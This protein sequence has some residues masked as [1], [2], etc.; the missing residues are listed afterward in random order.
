MGRPAERARR[1]IRRRIFTPVNRGHHSFEEA[2]TA[3]RAEIVILSR[4][5]RIGSRMGL[6]DFADD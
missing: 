4:Q 5:E 6:V 3:M 1:L 2:D